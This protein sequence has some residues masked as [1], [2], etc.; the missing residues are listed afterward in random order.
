MI[1][2]KNNILH[3]GYGDINVGHSLYTL[4]FRGFKPPIEVGTHISKEVIQENNIEWLTEMFYLD[5]RDIQEILTFEN[6][7]KQIIEN[8]GENFIQFKFKDFTFDFSNYN[9]K[10]VEVIL[11]QLAVVRNNLLQVI[12]C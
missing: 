8:G 1:D 4:I 5:L 2:I 10:S 11:L 3:F 9:K 7:L 12:A 6:L